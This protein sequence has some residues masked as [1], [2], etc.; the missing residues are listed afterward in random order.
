MG[1]PGQPAVVRAELRK[2]TMMEKESFAFIRLAVL[3]GAMILVL[4]GPTA[5]ATEDDVI[6][7]R[8]DDIIITRE[9]FEREVYTAA[10]Q[11]YYHGRPP[12][13]EE[14]IEFRKS[15]AEDM[16]DRQLLLREAK[17]RKLEPDQA[18]ID[19]KIA[20]YEARYGQTERWQ[21]EGPKM[22]AMLR[23]RFEEDG[24]VAALER[25]V[26]SVAP[27]EDATLRE[28]YDANPDLFTEPA[29][30][31][32]SLI[33][34]G[35]APSASAA[36]W[37]AVR[38]ES[39]RVRQRLDEGVPFDELARMH[40]SDT[41][42]EAGGDMGYLHEGMLSPNAEQAIADLEIGEISDPVQVLEGMAIFKL[43]EQQPS[44]LR[45]F[46]EV[47]ERAEELWLRDKGEEEWNLLVAELRS[48]SD[49]DVDTDYLASL[50]GSAT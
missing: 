33:L 41:T 39:A 49:V 22:V 29:R 44:S 1:R 16:I 27:P 8:V 10:R 34:L 12:S 43:T 37:K 4:T 11:T 17:R 5:A 13:G 3:A 48:A 21:S 47:R 46:D 25:D 20:S 26:R 9:E 30:N 42:A 24:L 23:E 14:F 15:V 28:Y 45:S 50:P 40:S 6:L 38:E 18:R 31:R 19:A 7:A 32:V 36:T 2:G 35:V